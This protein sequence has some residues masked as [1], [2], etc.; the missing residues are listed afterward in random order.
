M[1]LETFIPAFVTF[2]VVI[3]PVGIAPVFASLTSGATAP[4]RRLMAIKSVFIGAVIL[5]GFAFGGEWLLG[6]IGISIDAMR[7]SGG[8]LLFII[9]LE[10][11]FEKRSER[12][13][14]RADELA[15]KRETPQEDVSVFPLAIPMIA[16]PGSIATIMLLMQRS[17]G[18]IA[19]SGTVIAAV[20]A[21]LSLCL[22]CFLA[23][24]KIMAL[25][26][27]TVSMTIS[28]ILGVILAALAAQLIFDAIKNTFLI[29]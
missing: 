11:V 19:A 20:G 7:A 18:D 9:A 29:G 28:R 1:N 25:L 15:E 27:Q 5:L 23:A 16:G 8:V 2:F 14:N 4:H 6:A 21:N 17:G 12:R 26:G 24:S 3:D 22:I 10:M 13:Q